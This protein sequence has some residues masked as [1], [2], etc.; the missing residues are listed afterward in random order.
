MQ[1][2]F[3]I[4][5][6][7]CKGEGVAEKSSRNFADVVGG[8]VDQ[9]IGVRAIDNQDIVLPQVESDSCLKK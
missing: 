8:E 2:R 5:S 9:S 7:A 1:P 6:L 4:P 3:F